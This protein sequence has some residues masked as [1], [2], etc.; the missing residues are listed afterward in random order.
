[1]TPKWRAR[2]VLLTIGTIDAASHDPEKWLPLLPGTTGSLV[3]VTSRRR[4]TAGGRRG[5]NLDIHSRPVRQRRCSPGSRPGGYAPAM[6]RWVRLPGCAV[7]G[8]WRRPATIATPASCCGTTRSGGPPRS[9]L[10]IWRRP[11]TALAVMRA[12]GCR[13]RPCS[14]HPTLRPH[15]TAQQAVPPAR[16]PPGYQTSFRCAAAALGH[17]RLDEA[18]RR[19]DELY[20]QHLLAEPAPGRYRLHDLLREHARALAAARRPCRL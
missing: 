3:L 18:R 1:M 10:P 19:L 5:V 14:A 4:L 16:A 15:R 12:Q 8:R 20:D 2:K 9:S 11:G 17:T 6:P 13:S 7:T